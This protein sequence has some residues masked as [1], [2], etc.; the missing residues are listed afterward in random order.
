MISRKPVFVFIYLIMFILSLFGMTAVAFTE[1]SFDQT[2]TILDINEN[3]IINDND[4][5]WWTHWSGDSDRNRLEDQ[6]DILLEQSYKSV[7]K[8]TANIMIDY[9]DAPDEN[10]IKKLNQLGLDITYVDDS[11]NMVAA[12]S[13]PADR[14]DDI[15]MLSGV[16]MIENQSEYIPLL[17]KSVPAMKVTAS[18]EYSNVARDFGVSGSGV[19]IAVIDTG[20]DDEH[21]SLDDDKFIEGKDF[22]DDRI[23]EKNP[24]DKD[25]HGTHVA[26]IAMGNGGSTGSYAGV[27]PGAK[28][29]DVKVFSDWSPTTSASN[30]IEAIDWCIANK[31]R[32][33]IDIL[34]LSIGDVFL[35]NDDGNSAEARKVDEASSAGMVVV[36][37]AGNE[38]PNNNGFSSLA[39]AETAITVG[40]IDDHGTVDRS[41]DTIADFSNRGPRADDG[42]SESIDEFKPDVCAP[43]V[44]INSA[45]GL[46]FGS[47]GNSYTEKDGTS[48]SAPHVSGLAALILEANPNLNPEDVKKIIRDT[49]SPMGS[50][51]NADISSQY[52]SDYGWGIVDA[53]E[54]VKRALG[55]FQRAEIDSFEDGDTIG[56]L[57][58][59]LGTASNDKGPIVK[60]ELSFNGGKTWHS[61][62]GTYDWNYTWDSSE[63]GNGET[64]IFIRT[65]N[66]TAYSDIFKVSV[67]VLNVLAKISYP[68]INSEVKGTVKIEGALS[69]NHFVSFVAVKIDNGDWRSAKDKTG[70][71]E[72]STWYYEWNTK[73]YKNGEHTIYA[74]THINDIVSK[75]TSITVKVENESGGGF[76]TLRLFI[77][78]IIVVIIIAVLVA[79]MRSRRKKI[80]AIIIEEIKYQGQYKD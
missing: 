19:V 41:D 18:N 61:A 49:A 35:G 13:V 28:L 7:D 33:S 72:W 50:P 25:G 39:A 11:I 65:S 54:A 78:I 16:V 10:D 79:V 62:H 2:V 14:L 53:Y 59:I 77:L 4:P 48:M 38:G 3:Y 5:P 44:A 24:D 23:K 47:A 26:G 37:S 20:V 15:L 71:G 32:L 40:A 67:N 9:K 64:Q 56:G 36:V 55:D 29:V 27:A 60:V 21:D 52:N 76:L 8:P 12:D 75:E 45:M 70:V 34:S 22:S 30:V 66:G 68:Y 58:E 6:L 57:V 51:Y 73:P 74:R 42:D 1:R 43:G 31:V 69:V 80:E 46:K 63:T 17:D